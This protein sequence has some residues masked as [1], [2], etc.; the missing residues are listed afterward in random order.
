MLDHFIENRD[1]V[2]RL[3]SGVIGSQLDSFATHLAQCEYAAA[4]IRA[5]L[6]LLG[7]FSQWLTRRGCGIH[8]LNDELV[9]T[10]VNDRKAPWTVAP[11]PCGDAP[12]ISHPSPSARCGRSTRTERRR[13]SLEPAAA[14]LRAAP[15][16]RAGPRTIYGDELWRG[17]PVVSDRS[18]RRRPAGF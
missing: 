8:E 5:Q 15:E 7:H 18:V 11:W 12:S 3:R 14:A 17:V 1:R 4:T 9:G 10:F 6:T 13:I 16:G 2:R